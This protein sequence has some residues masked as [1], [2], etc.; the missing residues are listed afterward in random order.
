MTS[1]KRNLKEKKKTNQGQA[2]IRK[3][4][5]KAVTRGVLLKGA[6]INVANL[7]W[8]HLCQNQS[9]AWNFNKKETL[10]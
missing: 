6:L 7:T 1:N 5:T 9:E 3:E 4:S 2:H 10:E 8:K